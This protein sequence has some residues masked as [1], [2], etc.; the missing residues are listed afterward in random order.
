MVEVD[1][2]RRLAEQHP[3]FGP[4][5]FA[6]DEIDY[7]QAREN[8]FSHYAA[9]FAAKEAALKA[10]GSGWSLGFRWPEIAVK[11]QPGGRPSIELKSR[12]KRVA[13]RLGVERIRLSLTHTSAYV[14]AQV[15]FEN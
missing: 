4:C 3:S 1:R 6:P 7:C 5:I 14:S 10:L 2:I 12:S 11:S 9:R 8:S 13:E 15:L